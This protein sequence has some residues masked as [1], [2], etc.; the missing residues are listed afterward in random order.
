MQ[1]GL[2]LNYNFTEEDEKEALIIFFQKI[3]N[4]KI[5]SFQELSNG[6]FLK[7]YLES[8]KIEKKNFSDLENS[9]FFELD[10]KS[11]IIG[12]EKKLNNIDKEN[13]LYFKKNKNSFSQK[14]KDFS[15]IEKENFLI[16]EKE[17]YL[18]QSQ[19][20]NSI[21]N[22]I[23]FEKKENLEKNKNWEYIID[24]INLCWNSIF[25]FSEKILNFENNYFLQENQKIDILKLIVCFIY[26]KILKGFEFGI[27]KENLFY[28]TN[29]VYNEKSQNL[30][31]KH[32]ELIHKFIKNNINIIFFSK[33][34]F[35]QD[36]LNFAFNNVK[37]LLNEKKNFLKKIKIFE[38][39]IFILKKE[40]NEH[41]KELENNYFLIK[42]NENKKNNI[43]EN[44]KKI[45][46]FLEKE[47]IEKNK[48]LEEN[49]KLN[50]E[51]K[52]Y[53]NQ[54]YE[55]I[56]K[57]K[58]NENYF[59]NLKKEIKELK[60]E[61]LLLKKKNYFFENK[62]KNNDLKF[63]KKNKLKKDLFLPYVESNNSICILENHNEKDFK[64]SKI[65]NHNNFITKKKKNQKNFTNFI[66]FQYQKK[67]CYVDK[68]KI[69]NIDLKKKLGNYKLIL[70]L[71]LSELKFVYTFIK[72]YK[73]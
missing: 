49:K 47:K 58:E 25:E 5:S 24:H 28:S 45:E 68:E 2:N 9:L 64:I 46:N 11:L 10:N 34:G 51:I 60:K 29:L 13:F 36:F 40:N 43:F 23:I 63:S 72:K 57:D 61:N 27:E 12:S 53:I 3:L 8:K 65:Q 22:T 54:N 44:K 56:K 26:L 7:K 33:H 18:K 19:I 37:L 16:L 1:K 41:L 52:N 30:K 32:F 15:K 50:L 73:N 17:K 55:L 39:K 21:K 59:S 4:K 35:F 6:L 20:K 14:K 66:I 42:E 38:N 62:K 71:I 48:L 69:Q 31:N 67:I 70:K